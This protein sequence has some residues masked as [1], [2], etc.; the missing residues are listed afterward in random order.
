MPGGAAPRGALDVAALERGA[1]RD[2]PPPRGA[3]HDVRADRR[4]ADAGGRSPRRPPARWST[5]TCARRATREREAAL[6]GAATRPRRRSTSRRGPLLRAPLVRA[7]RAASTCCSSTLHHI[8]CDGWSLGVLVRE[9]AALYSALRA[10]RPSPLAALADPVRRLRRLAARAGSRATCSTRSSPTGAS[11]LAGA[12]PRSSCRPTGRARRCRASRR[13]ASSTVV[14][15]DARR[16]RCARSAAR[17]GVHAVH[18]AARGA[19]RRCCSATPARTTSSSARRSPNRH[20]AE[21]E[22][23][24]GFF[25]NTLVLRT[26][27]RR[28]R[29]SASCCA[30]CAS[31][32]L[33][34]YAHQDLPF[35]KLVD[36]AAAAAR[37]EPHAAVPGDVQRCRTRRCAAS[38]STG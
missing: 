38:R 26:D 7:R 31:A 19:S 37:P 24:I 23:L 34:A 14:A 8:V 11:A 22:A 5:S 35:E 2:R 15:A 13:P 1:G 30:A 18:D 21:I 28:R 17:E 9:L 32:A 3:A 33:G 20:A 25:V 10:G 16:P 29:R 12:P 36:D 27:S 4:R 6:A